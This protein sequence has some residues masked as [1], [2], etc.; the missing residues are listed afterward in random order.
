PP[1]HEA[2]VRGGKTPPAGASASLEAQ[3]RALSEQAGSLVTAMRTPQARGR[4][5]ELTLRRVAEL[6]GMG[7]HCD[8]VEQVTTESEGRR[9]R[10]DMV[11]HLPRRRQIVVDA[12]VPLT[13][14]L[15]AMEAPT[16]DQRRAAL[17]R[18]AQQVRA[19]VQALANKTSRD[20]RRRGRH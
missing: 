18:H 12:K 4:W 8:F 10:P 19:H 17:E 13:A 1:P 9:R 14:Y 3:V 5:G 11:V 16:P 2:P 15:E 6:A 7:G 20:A